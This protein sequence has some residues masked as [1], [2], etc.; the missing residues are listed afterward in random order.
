MRTNLKTMSISSYGV[1]LWNELED[2]L[3]R[4]ENIPPELSSDVFNAEMNC[5]STGYNIFDCFRQNALV[6][7]TVHVVKHA[8]EFTLETI[9]L[10]T[11]AQLIK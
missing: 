9:T 7:S 8:Q 5:I 3:K 4:C 2:E 1:T 10:R 6:H 11:S